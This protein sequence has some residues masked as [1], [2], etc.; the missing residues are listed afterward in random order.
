MLR[1]IQVPT[2]PEPLGAGPVDVYIDNTNNSEPY[3]GNFV[4]KYWGEN[5]RQDA[6]KISAQTFGL[7][8]AE[9]TASKYTIAIL[10]VYDYTYNYSYLADSAQNL[11]N[12]ENQLPFETGSTTYYS[13]SYD[14]KVPDFRAR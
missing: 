5:G 11:S 8:S 4:S 3:T 9:L 2:P 10:G 13:V 7:S 14:E 1:S 6:L 12:Y